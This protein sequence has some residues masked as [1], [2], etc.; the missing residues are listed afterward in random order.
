MLARTIVV[1][2]LI[3]SP[4]SAHLPRYI[5]HMVYCLCCGCILYEYSFG[6]MNSAD[7]RREVTKEDMARATLVTVTN[8][9]GAIARMCASVSVSH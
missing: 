3:V 5:D 1:L 6:H 9:I 2:L 7:R 4:F 8:N